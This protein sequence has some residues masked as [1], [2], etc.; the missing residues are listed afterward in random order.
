MINFFG[1]AAMLQALI[2]FILMFAGGAGGPVPDAPNV[3][4]VG[5]ILF[6][7]G[8]IE[9]ILFFIYDRLSLIAQLMGGAIKLFD[10]PRASPPTPPAPGAKPAAPPQAPPPAPLI[11]TPVPARPATARD[12]LLGLPPAEV[13]R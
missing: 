2:G 7:A 1:A 5:A 13:R 10:P 12:Q 6:V 4:V 9:V 8:I 3:A 11:R